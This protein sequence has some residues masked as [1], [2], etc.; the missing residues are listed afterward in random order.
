MVIPVPSTPLLDAMRSIASAH[1]AP[2][3]DVIRAYARAVHELHGANA[4]VT[5]RV[6]GIDRRTLYR[7]CAK[8]TLDATP[9]SDATP[10]VAREDSV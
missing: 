10:I 9:S 3:G 7:W 1:S 4:T 2:V 5:A 6:L 8:W